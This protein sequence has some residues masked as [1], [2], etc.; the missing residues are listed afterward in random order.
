MCIKA[1]VGVHLRAL[2]AT[3]DLSMFD[4]GCVC[5][6]I[7]AKCEYPHFL[8]LTPWASL[9]M[10]N[11]R[12]THSRWASLTRWVTPAMGK[13][14]DESAFNVGNT[15]ILLFFWLISKSEKIAG[16]DADSR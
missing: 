15:Q 13:T 8:T 3:C 12:A 16:E 6:E 7:F 10:G 4:K 1:A 11:T 5:A 2:L 9:A 14:H